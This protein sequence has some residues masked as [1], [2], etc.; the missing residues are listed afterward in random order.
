MAGNID[1]GSIRMTRTQA[2]T[3]RHAVSP[4]AEYDGARSAVREVFD[5]VPGQGRFRTRRSDPLAFRLDLKVPGG[6]V[7]LTC[8]KQAD[9][10]YALT[11]EERLRDHEA[12]ANMDFVR[13]S[14]L[15][16]RSAP[17]AFA[18]ARGSVTDTAD[19]VRDLLRR[20]D[21][22]LTGD[23]VGDSLRGMATPVDGGIG[24]SFSAS[25]GKSGSV[26]N[27]DAVASM[28][29][30]VARDK[31]FVVPFMTKGDAIVRAAY[32][33]AFRQ[34]VL[35][36]GR[37]ALAEARA[38]GRRVDAEA[39]ADDVHTR[40]GL[41]AI[42]AMM[43]SRDAE[44]YERAIALADR[45]FEVLQRTAAF[46]GEFGISEEKADEAC[47]AVLAQYLCEEQHA[48]VTVWGVDPLA[49]HDRTEERTAGVD[50]PGE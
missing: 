31:W 27:A 1:R 22:T 12:E 2:F 20:C 50:L 41:A 32:K 28:A 9:G 13:L 3:L 35:E 49:V 7:A 39:F 43:E 29:D 17:F 33:S 46:L 24:T 10:T 8:E 21:L 14:E 45:R 25:A 30:L 23:A 4:T 5:A 48:D 47:K 16:R 11:G 26:T 36:A 40:D 38:E 6:D 34:H 42:A 37:E 18:G 19:N 44:Q 15:C